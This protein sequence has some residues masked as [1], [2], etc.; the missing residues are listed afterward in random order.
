MPAG[1]EMLPL[2]VGQIAQHP[3]PGSASE[4]DPASDAE[5]HPMTTATMEPASDGA[6][7]R[8]EPEDAEILPA[9]AE[10]AVSED[11]SAQTS[12]PGH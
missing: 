5:P 1:T 7:V 12:R 9:D 11:T 2:I 6:P 3:E 4:P 10:T 8:Q